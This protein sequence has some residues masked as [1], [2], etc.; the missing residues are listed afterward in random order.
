[1]CDPHPDLCKC[2]SFWILNFYK[3]YFILNS[4]GEIEANMPEYAIKTPL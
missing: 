1:M 3:Y 4:S 2:L